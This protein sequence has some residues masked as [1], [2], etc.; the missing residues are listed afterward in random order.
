ML[1]YISRTNKLH[2]CGAYRQLHQ[3]EPGVHCLAHQ[4][5]IR[6]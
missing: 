4:R 3:F 2:E 6:L 1:L 5:C